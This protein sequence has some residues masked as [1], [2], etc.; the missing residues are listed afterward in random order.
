[1]SFGEV[2][3]ADPKGPRRTQGPHRSEEPGRRGSVIAAAWVITAIMAASVCV[4]V[5]RIPLQV[6]DTLVPLLEAQRIPSVI[7]A[8]ESGATNAGYF[9]PFRAAQIQALFNAANGHYHVAF[10]AFQTAF[11]VVVFVLFLLALHVD[12][13]PRLAA[14]LFALTV[15]MGMHT[16]RGTVWE[17]YPVNHSLEVVAFC[18]LALVLSQSNGGW[19]ADAAAALTLVAAV[20]TVESG[21][22]VWV[23]V[24]AAWLTGARGISTRGVVVLTVLVAAYFALRF[25]YLG[26]GV[27]ALSERSSGFGLRQLGPGELQ[28]RFGE[29]PYGFYAYNVMSSVLTVLFSEPRAGIWTVPAE[30]ARGRVAAGSLINIVSSAVTTT[31]VVWAAVRALRVGYRGNS[32]QFGRDI[33][34]MAVSLAVIGANAVISYGYTKDE[35]MGPAGVFYAIAAFVAAVMLL[36]TIATAGARIPQSAIAFSMLIASAGWVERTV[37]LHYHMNLMA[38]YDRNEWVFVDDW[39]AKQHAAPATDAGRMLVKQL[40]NEAIDGKTVNPYLLSPRLDQ[41]FR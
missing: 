10:K 30:L 35:I 4:S 26:T 17:A 13:M 19:W 39:L 11:V 41:W 36:S 40:Q 5:F 27:P 14:L 1:M 34:L 23:V 31:I 2:M 21:L 29:W 18:L 33:Q 9:R 37:G 38:F 20:L 8:F 25:G 22:L 16:F 12:S 28:Q 3:D 6:T 15:L 32:P 24:A 7:A